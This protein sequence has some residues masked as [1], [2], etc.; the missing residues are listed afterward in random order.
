MGSEMCIRDSTD[1]VCFGTKDSSFGTF[2]IRQ[3]GDMYNLKLVHQS[4][5]VNC[6]NDINSATNWGC[7]ASNHD[8]KLNVHI[9]N[10]S[11]ARIFPPIG[12]V[13]FNG[14]LYYS[15]PGFHPNSAEIVFD[16]F[17]A[18]LSVTI[19]QRFRVWYGE[20]LKKNQEGDNMGKSC[21]D[22]YGFY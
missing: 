9:T 4:G 17:P 19:G 7:G 8:N 20:D 11:N 6:I 21:I 22:V 1:P 3:S 14:H 10:E 15:L 5:A 16:V 2:E 12:S 13:N 18:P